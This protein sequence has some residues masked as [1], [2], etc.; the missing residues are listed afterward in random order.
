MVKKEEKAPNIVRAFTKATNGC[1]ELK[2]DI[3]EVKGKTNALVLQII[4]PDFSLN[5]RS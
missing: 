1:L 4:T 3:K 2:L 5:K